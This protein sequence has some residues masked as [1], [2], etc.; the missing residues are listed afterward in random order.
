M[1]ETF[2]FVVVGSGGGSMC[3]A[4][5]MAAVGKKTLILE[6]TDLI[7][8]STAMAGGVMWIP[9]NP[10]QKPEGV[11][12]SYD[13]A[14][15][16]L[17]ALGGDR[18]NA[19]GGTRERQM[20]YLSEAPKMIDFLIDKGIKLRRIPYWPDYNDDL[21]GGSEEGRTVV[22]ELFDSNE[23]GE[24]K[25]KLRP[26]FLA[27]PAKLDEA[28][29]VGRFKTTWAGKRMLA[30][31]VLRAVT[32]KIQ[33]KHY[34]TAGNAL[35]GRMLQAAVKAGVEFRTDAAVHRLVTDAKGA[36]TG[37]VATIDG[38][39]TR[40]GSRNGVLVNA[41]GFAR[42]QRMRDKYQ[43]GTSVKW[44]YACV[45]DT[46]EMIE[47]MMRIGADIAQMEEM[48]GCYMALPPEVNDTP[49]MVQGDVSSPHSMMVDQSG[50]RFIR[51]AQSY[52]TFGQQMLAHDKI[53]PCI[54]SWMIF[55][56]QYLKKYMLAGSMPGTKKPQ[57]WYDSGFLKKGETIEEL[58]AACKLDPRVLRAQVD[59]FNGFAR[60]GKD[61]DFHRGDR[62][63]DNYLGDPAHKPSPTLGTIEKGPF[64]AV[65]IYPGD[66]GTY[67][68]VVTD[69]QARVLRED[70]SPI[71]G[72]YATGTSTASVMGR[73]YP[74]AGSSIGPAF[75]WGY[76]AA[77]DAANAHNLAL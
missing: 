55:D 14:L 47:E 5:V 18:A 20:A 22:A 28:M 53:T 43:P 9:N 17:D 32:Q 36:V 33:G 76:V 48:V 70:G 68:G 6:K 37:V 11:E 58:A 2:D 44:T 42:N 50:V 26:N 46:G 73:S 75:T 3:A 59:R 77:K 19:P 74:G 56:T 63:Y 29:K 15:T 21:P 72:L 61:E 16:Y 64:Y 35:Q 71:P 66:V 10:F 12:D 25:K 34:V 51:E 30:R 38:K 54:P 7:G 45:G 62:A 31:I 39:E 57:N 69:V 24:W 41:G 1:D 27:L 67:G 52:M 65:E 40:I 23:L 60:N 4:L 13:K 8:G 49:S